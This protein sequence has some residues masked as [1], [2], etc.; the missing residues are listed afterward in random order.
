MSSFICSPQK[1]YKGGHCYYSYLTHGDLKSSGVQDSTQG[2]LAVS[3]RLV[4]EPRTPGSST[5]PILQAVHQLG[6]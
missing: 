6:K 3:S 4:F 2:Y 1:P 5:A